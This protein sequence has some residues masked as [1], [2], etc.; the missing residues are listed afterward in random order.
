[1]ENINSTGKDFSSLINFA[2]R[3]NNKVN[4][5]LY[6][7]PHKLDTGEIISILMLALPHLFFEL[8]TGWF[9]IISIIL[10]HWLQKNRTID[11][12]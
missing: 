12:R 4:A 2:K 8:Y 10:R 6:Y 9:K 7:Y 5:K 1:M 11:K 3:S